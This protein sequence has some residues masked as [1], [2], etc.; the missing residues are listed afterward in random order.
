MSDT[1]QSFRSRSGRRGA[2]VSHLV[3]AALI[4]LTLVVVVACASDPKS[5]AET[6]V[7][8][9]EGFEQMVQKTVDDPERSAQL[10]ALFD[11]TSGEI[12]EHSDLIKRKQAELKAAARQY[13]TTDAEL[14]VILADLR[15]ELL[16]AR[17]TLATL[18]FE[19][20]DIVTR[21]EWDQIIN[22]KSKLF[23]IF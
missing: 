17:G 13:E 16:A 7:E 9:L 18:H 5:E 15:R 1:R 8:Q 11:G 2:R 10:K 23:G 19:I 3:T 12:T 20:R 14:E 21:Q 6:T 22:H 4:G